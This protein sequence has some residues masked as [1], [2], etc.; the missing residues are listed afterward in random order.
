[1]WSKCDRL[2]GDADRHESKAHSRFNAAIDRVANH[3][4]AV[5][6]RFMTGR[7][8]VAITVNG[9][10]LR[11]WDP[12]VQENDA[13]QHLGAELLSLRRIPRERS[14]HMCSHTGRS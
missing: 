1:M 8:K 5:F 2:V 12:F 13:T 4:S 7:G 9:V 11:P 14:S 10:K 6:H 3:L